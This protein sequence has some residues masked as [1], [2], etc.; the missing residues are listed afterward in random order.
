M[1]PSEYPH[2]A[3]T[4]FLSIR[5]RGGPTLFHAGNARYAGTRLLYLFTSINPVCIVLHTH[6]H[7]HTHLSGKN[8]QKVNINLQ[9]GLWKT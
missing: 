3:M 2:V 7:T 8:V 6:T 9:A 4:L 1:S 5:I